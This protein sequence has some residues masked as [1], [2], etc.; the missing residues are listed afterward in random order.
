MQDIANKCLNGKHDA[1]GKKIL[2]IYRL[3]V[4]RGLRKDNIARI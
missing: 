1:F 4:K 3:M 2:Q